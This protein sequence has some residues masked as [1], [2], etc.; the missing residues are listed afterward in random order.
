MLLTIESKVPHDAIMYGWL[1]LYEVPLKNLVEH[2]RRYERAY[3]A[4]ET[5]RHTRN[6]FFRAGTGFEGYFVGLYHSPEE[7]LTTLL[8][9]GHDM[10]MSTCRLYRHQYT[11]KASLMKTLVG[12]LSDPRAIGVWS[13]MLGAALAKLR[14]NVHLNTATYRFQ[15]ETYWTVNRLPLIRYEQDDHHLEQEYSL[16]PFQNAYFS[17]QEFS[18]NLLK[19]SDYDAGLVV[20]SVGRFGHPLIRAYLGEIHKQGWHTHH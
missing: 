17:K 13:A 16:A 1:H 8:D 7:M 20:S 3:L 2:S 6:P 15:N 14:C 18:P 12:E 9:I 19:P 4:W 5:V 11:F 10:L